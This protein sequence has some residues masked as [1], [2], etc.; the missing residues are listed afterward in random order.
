MGFWSGVKNFIIG[1]GD[2]AQKENEEVNMEMVRL[3]EY[4]D[5]QLKRIV[6]TRW[7]AEKTAAARLLAERGYGKRSYDDE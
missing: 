3:K 4:D 6:R 7:G 1:M 5:E 2:N